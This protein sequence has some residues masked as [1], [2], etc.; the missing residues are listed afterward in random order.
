MH[1]LAV[2]SRSP[3]EGADR[4]TPVS[5]LEF[6]GCDPVRVSEAE[7]ESP[8]WEGRRVEYWHGASET[9]WIMRE[10]VSLYHEGPAARLA[11]LVRQIGIARGSEVRCIGATDLRFREADGRLGD[12]MQADQALYLD[13]DRAELSEYGKVIVGEDELPDVLLEVDNT[14][15]VRR[16]KLVAYADWRLPEVWVEVPDRGSPS[17][18]RGLRPGLRIYLLDED[19]YRESEESRAFPGWTA[20]EIHRA[21]NETR[22]SEAT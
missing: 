10:A 16:G 5:E 1:R 18:P 9:A 7:F 14:T 22:M 21:L 13:P 6:V 20:D 4:R 11:Q 2:G 15:D 17:R 8:A 19:G 12:I 3:A